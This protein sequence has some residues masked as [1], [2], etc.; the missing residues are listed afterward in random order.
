MHYRISAESICTDGIQVCGDTEVIG[1][2]RG[3]ITAA[4]SER[5][6]L[7]KSCGRYLLFFVLNKCLKI[8][9]VYIYFLCFV[10]T[11]CKVKWTILVEWGV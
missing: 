3:I 8:K 10:Y 6:R 1:R 9:S 11:K 4:R 5:Y 7:L 2:F